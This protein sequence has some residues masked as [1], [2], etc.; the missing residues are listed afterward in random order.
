M[1]DY[2][3]YNG[4]QDTFRDVVQGDDADIVENGMTSNESC[5]V[6]ITE[7][8]RGDNLDSIL[9]SM[10]G[11]DTCKN[12]VKSNS[13]DSEILNSLYTSLTMQEHASAGFINEGASTA[14][15][16]GSDASNILS[17]IASNSSTE[18]CEDVTANVM[19]QMFMKEA[20]TCSLI[21]KSSKIEFSGG[22]NLIIEIIA[23]KAV[24]DI[25]SADANIQLMAGIVKPEPVPADP[26]VMS[27]LLASGATAQ[28]L[29][30]YVA[31]QTRLTTIAMEGYQDLVKSLFVPSIVIDRVIMD[32][33]MNQMWQTNTDLTEDDMTELRTQYKT[34]ALTSAENTIQHTTGFGSVDT[35]SARLAMEEKLRSTESNIDKMIKNTLN[36][37]K[38]TQNTAGTIRIKSGG[39]IKMGDV[40]LNAHIEQNLQAESLLQSAISFGKILASELMASQ[41]TT[42]K[43]KFTQ[44]GAEAVADSFGK[45][46]ASM[47]KAIQEG[48]AN[49]I[50]AAQAGGGSLLIFGI[51]FL[52]MNRGGGGGGGGGKGGSGIKKILF[53]IIIAIII[54]LVAAYFIGFW[55][56]KK[57]EKREKRFIMMPRETLEKKFIMMPNKETLVD[58]SII[59]T[60]GTKNVKYNKEFNVSPLSAYETA[61]S[62]AKNFIF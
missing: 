22:T 16:A 62:R 24:P 2:N 34:A 5:P 25:W 9:S 39:T 54:Y 56:F 1:A 44:A 17:T 18:G 43:E 11:G 10:G 57:K 21:D 41:S 46:N 48:E 19:E 52:M 23:E 55:P 33:T 26:L 13:K 47:E 4:T 61:Q 3:K 59:E 49:K 12:S 29:N 60:L 45:A 31:Q 20:I 32:V 27:A 53:F 14:F 7:K 38:V 35:T 40:I 8:E 50:K 36:E 51:I 6:A 42:N 58:P 28:D 30:T 37:T 15:T